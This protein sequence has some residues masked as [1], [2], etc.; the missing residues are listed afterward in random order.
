MT[1]IS[2]WRGFCRNFSMYTAGLP[3]AA[4]ASALVICTALTSAASVCTTRM[5]RPPPPPAAGSLDDHGVAHG[6]GDVANLHRVI[7]QFPLG[8]GHTGHAGADHGLLGRH[9]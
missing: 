5:P 8:A 1:W 7:G 3:N 2:I 9:L 4:P 6:L